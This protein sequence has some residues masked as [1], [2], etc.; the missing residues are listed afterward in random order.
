MK[1][2]IVLIGGGGHCKSVIDVIENSEEFEIARIIDVR[3]RRNTKILKYK[4][5]D[6]DE[7]I[8]ELHKKFKNFCIT[9]GHIKDNKLRI[10]L[11]K[12]LKQIGAYLPV[13]RS[14]SSHCSKHSFIGEGTV[15]MNCVNVNASA[16]IG[17]N[18]IINTGCIIEH[19]TEIG[20]HCHI[21]TGAVING[22]V[23]IGDN[24]FIG[25]N[26]VV[27]QEIRIG[28][29]IIVGSGSVVNKNIDIAGLYA[30]NPVKKLR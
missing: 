9:I 22:G 10:V 17:V 16:D 8:P 12:R 24:V 25:S 23:K 13:I 28:R 5:T 1:K 6:T 15:I 4:I 27:N 11:Y 19:D 30:G 26:S 20:N 3:E 14:K 18:N 2:K 7:N 21:S 29:D